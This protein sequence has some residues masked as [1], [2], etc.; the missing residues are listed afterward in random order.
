MRSHTA[1]GA[2]GEPRAVEPSFDMPDDEGAPPPVPSNPDRQA[3]MRAQS[4][5]AVAA[6]R[7]ANPTD[8]PENLDADQRDALLAA[9]RMKPK[10]PA[11]RKASGLPVSEMRM[12]MLEMASRVADPK[13]GPAGLIE[14]AKQLLDFVSEG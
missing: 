12:R 3:I 14:A 6:E 10:S 13:A 9:Q 11:M 5:A 2:N 8:L 1:A 4:L 7:A